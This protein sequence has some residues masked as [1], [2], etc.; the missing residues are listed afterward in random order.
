MSDIKA[1]R[2]NCRFA[3]QQIEEGKPVL[4]VQLYQETIPVLKNT[5]LGFG[6]LGGMLPEQAKKLAELL[7]EQ[8]LEVFV[9]TTTETAL[10][11]GKSR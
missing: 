2:S 8:V 10:P 1:D 3:V 4:L 7:N 6:L 9:R 11:S 5:T